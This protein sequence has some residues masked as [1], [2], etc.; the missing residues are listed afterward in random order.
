MLA[1]YHIMAG[2]VLQWVLASQGGQ[3]SAWQLPAPEYERQA[4]A[5]RC[6][7]PNDHSACLHASHPSQLLRCPSQVPGRKECT[8]LARR[9][10]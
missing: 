5:N 9:C 2:G 1:L 7:T 6:A 3:R 10:V 4:D 8:F